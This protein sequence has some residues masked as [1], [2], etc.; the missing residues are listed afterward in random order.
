M[1]KP[2]NK[3]R[4]NLLPVLLGV[5]GLFAA[6]SVSFGAVAFDA[7]FSTYTLGTL[8]GQNSWAQIGTTA[9][10][11]PIQVIAAA[12]AVPQSIRITGVASA[13]Q[14]YRD[15]PT[16]SRFDP[17]TVT[18]VKTFYYVLENFK[19]IAALNSTS[20]TGQGFC[21]FTATAGGTGATTSRLFLRRFGG[22][23]ANTT[24]FDLGVSASG[25]AA[26]YGTTPLTVGSS[27]KIVVAYTANL[28]LANDVVK[29]YVN[30][31]G[32]DP[33]T[34]SHEV[35]Q[36]ATTDPTSSF[37]SFGVTPGTVN[38]GTKIDLTIGRI[39]VGDS[40]SDVLPPPV[41]PV[42][43][44]ATGISASGFTANWGTA[45]GATKYYLD[46]AT[47]SGF[48]AYVA[49]FEN[50]DVLTAVSKSV[51]GTFTPGQSV[52]YRVR[53]WNSNGPSGNSST[54]EVVITA[55]P[56]V[57]VPTV[58]NST[59]SG[60]VTWTSGPDWIP[61]NPVSASNATVTFNGVLNGV[62]TA[63]NDTASPFVLNSLVFANSGAGTN[64]ITG[65]VLQLTNN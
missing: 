63:N 56:A 54:Q 47:D 9:T 4:K 65:G 45:S 27:Y 31:I 11:S 33:A 13:A 44:E 3:I 30:P 24:T 26:V 38:N 41:T 19:V 36:T 43:S 12:G 39:I 59:T 22:V 57:L 1:N 20:S 34:W 6:G 42:V 18:E 2:T 48:T 28:G 40:P 10:A 5:A 16:A 60:T 17:T 61:N 15:L 14:S 58:T 25:A 62:L 29:V 49:G 52:F 64:D 46:V 55:A 21:A 37:K 35:T 53:A 23:T 32:L 8:N 50:L 7:D 51:T